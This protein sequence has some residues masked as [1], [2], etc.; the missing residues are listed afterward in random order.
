MKRWAWPNLEE[1]AS[2]SAREIFGRDYALGAIWVADD[3]E[4][5]LAGTWNKALLALEKGADGSWAGRAHPVASGG[6]Y[7]ASEIT[8]AR[9]VLFTGV[10]GD[11]GVYLYDLDKGR[12]FELEDLDQTPYWSVS[13]PGGENACVL[14]DG[15]VL[16]YRIRRIESGTLTY[17]LRAFPGTDLGVALA[18]CLLP[19]N[20]RMAAVTEMGQLRFIDPMALSSGDPIFVDR[21]E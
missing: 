4:T 6:L 10:E 21:L 14:G 8:K 13:L 18:A 16:N 7:A 11:H 15:A 20:E 19:G 5:I 3:E 17:E 12:L 2:L 1:E 9:A